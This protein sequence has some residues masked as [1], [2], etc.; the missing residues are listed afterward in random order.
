MALG[1]G[2][3]SE[4]ERRSGIGVFIPNGPHPLPKAD[5]SQRLPRWQHDHK[6]GIGEHGEELT[7]LQTSSGI[8]Q[9][10]DRKGPIAR[11]SKVMQNQRTLKLDPVQVGLETIRR[12]RLAAAKRQG[13]GADGQ[14]HRRAGDELAVRPSSLEFA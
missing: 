12:F 1:I 13:L 2:I 8:V 11:S 3:K 14:G 10:R 4:E 6:L 7:R 9:R 5:L